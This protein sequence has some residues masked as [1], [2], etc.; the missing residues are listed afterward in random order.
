MLTAHFA[1]RS[2]GVKLYGEKEFVTL[3][4]QPPADGSNVVSEGRVRVV[5]AVSAG[6]IAR[7]FE[8]ILKGTRFLAL[9]PQKRGKSPK[10]VVRK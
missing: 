7:V 2:I 10:A 4:F 3:D 1:D 9:N 6:Q 8:R 5:I